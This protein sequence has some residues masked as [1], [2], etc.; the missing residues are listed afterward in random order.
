MSNAKITLHTNPPSLLKR[1]I[2]RRFGRRCNST[3]FEMYEFRGVFYI[4]GELK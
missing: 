4:L 2:V 1:W 3:V